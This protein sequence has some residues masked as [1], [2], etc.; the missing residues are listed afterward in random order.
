MDIDGSTRPNW[1]W[2]SIWGVGVILVLE[3]GIL[4]GGLE[5][6]KEDGKKG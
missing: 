5:E 6:G 3:K 1:L 2:L 4:R